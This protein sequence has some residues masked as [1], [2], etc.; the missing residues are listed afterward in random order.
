MKKILIINTVGFE[1]DGIT[2]VILNYT[3]GMDRRNLQFVFPV[4][5]EINSALKE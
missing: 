5:E 4:Y 3:K 2:S 1:Y